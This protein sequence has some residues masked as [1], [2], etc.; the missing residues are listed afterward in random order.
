MVEPEKTHRDENGE[1]RT[2][3]DDLQEQPLIAIY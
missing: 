1:K 3:T 2:M